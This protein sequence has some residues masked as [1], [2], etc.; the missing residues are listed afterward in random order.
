MITRGRPKGDNAE[1]PAL[2]AHG[3]VDP[4]Q[5]RGKG[6]NA[7]D[8][9]QPVH[10]PRRGSS[11][12]RRCN[13]SLQRELRAAQGVWRGMRRLPPGREGGRPLG[14]LQGPFEQRPLG[15][16]YPCPDVLEH[17]R[18]GGDD[19]CARQLP[20]AARLRREGF[21]LLARVRPAGQ[22]EHNGQA[23]SGA[24]GWHL[25]RRRDPRARGA[26]GSGSAVRGS[27]EAETP[28]GGGI[29]ARI[30]PFLPRTVPERAHPQGR[31]AAQEPRQLLQG[32]GCRA[33]RHRVLH[34]PPARRSRLPA[35]HRRDHQAPR[36]ALAPARGATHVHGGDP[37]PEVDDR[38]HY[39]QPADG[40]RQSHGFR[41][42][43]LAGGG[44]AFGQRHRGGSRL[45]QTIRGVRH[46]R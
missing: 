27:G 7:P 29:Q 33:A 9:G 3:T 23:A 19:A 15:G 1:V 31:P 45:G 28:V 16:R 43:R 24:P 17:Q 40:H 11:G 32:G 8:E 14:R 34:R 46:R 41:Q 18:R 2:V 6:P 30:P 20:W 44:D 38:A 22:A 25:R 42:Q 39:V 21:D 26:L 5:P 4:T 12:V 35:R 36:R 37:V 13:G 10:H